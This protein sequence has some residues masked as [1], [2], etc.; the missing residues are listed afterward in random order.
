MFAFG[1]NGVAI[2]PNTK[3]NI[4]ALKKADWLVV[5]EIYPDET[6]EFW[7]APGTTPD[8]M[9]TIPTTAYR[10]P[11]AGLC[12]E[13]W[14]LRELRA[15]APMEKRRGPDARRRP[16]GSGHPRADLPQGARALSAG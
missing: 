4:E 3:K 10:L 7:R 2:G 5:G 16:A 6:S 8:D 13:G 14:R 9:K 12:G 15:L 11:C 1:M